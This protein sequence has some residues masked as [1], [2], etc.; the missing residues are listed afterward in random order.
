MPAKLKAAPK[1]RIDNFGFEAKSRL[2]ADIV[3]LEGIL[4]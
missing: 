1:D 4:G 3:E 2:A